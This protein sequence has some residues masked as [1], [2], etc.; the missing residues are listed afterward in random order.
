[1]EGVPTPLPPTVI[2]RQEDPL[3]GPLMEEMSIY[4]V[5]TGVKEMLEEYLRRVLLQKPKD[6]LEFLIKEIKE[7]PFVAPPEP[8]PVDDRPEEV[9]AKFLD[10]RRDETKMDLLREIFDR[11]D[12][13]KTGTVARAQVLVAFQNEKALLLEKFPKHVTELPMAL[14]KMDCGNKHGKM[15]WEVFSAG[16]MEALKKPGGL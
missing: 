2:A 13:K 4:A 15:S 3:S 16:L 1:M 11:F 14:E 7:N 9:K 10:I 6:P 8:E 12:P 5:K